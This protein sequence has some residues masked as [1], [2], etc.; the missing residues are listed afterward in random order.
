M[1]YDTLF[2]ASVFIFMFAVV[3]H[4]FSLNAFLKRL[5]SHHRETFARLGSP[6]WRIHFGDPVIQSTVKWIKTKEFKA[7]NDE[8][9]DNSYKVMRIANGVGVMAAVTAILAMLIPVFIQA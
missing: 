9:L 1:I 5:A 7:L 4:L 8:E 3:M 2:I 6:R